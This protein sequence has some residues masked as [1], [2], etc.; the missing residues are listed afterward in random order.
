[1]FS[2]FLH[3]AALLF[4]RQVGSCTASSPSCSACLM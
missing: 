2:K 1:M 3:A 4:P